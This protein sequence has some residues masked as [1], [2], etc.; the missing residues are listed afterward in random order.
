MFSQRVLPS[1]HRSPP[2]L[3]QSLTTTTAAMPYILGDAGL[4]AGKFCCL[5]GCRV[6]LLHLHSPRAVPIDTEM[7]ALCTAALPRG[8]ARPRLA[9]APSAE[10]RCYIPPCIHCVSID[11]PPR[12][13]TSSCRAQSAQHAAGTHAA[14]P[15]HARALHSHVC[16]LVGRAWRYDT[17]GT[18]PR[19]PCEHQ[20]RKPQSAVLQSWATQSPA[21]TPR[22]AAAVLTKGILA[23]R[24]MNRQTLATAARIHHPA[25]IRLLRRQPLAP[26]PAA[27]RPP[28]QQR[29]LYAPYVLTFWQDVGVYACMNA[30]IFPKLVPVGRPE[31]L[32]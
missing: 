19:S 3:N 24:A 6:H 9:T 18:A 17:T 31:V 2:T 8:S 5:G 13:S 10:R 28:C 21:R 14:A 12:R 7:R 22:Q 15:Q 23:R 30:R 11:L 26:A 20:L 32:G 27:P 4:V 29:V 16:P 1:L 25:I